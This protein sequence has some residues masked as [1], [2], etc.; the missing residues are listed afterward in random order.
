MGRFVQH[1]LLLDAVLDL[2]GEVDPESDQDGETRDGD[3]RQVH[4]DQTQDCERPDHPD[5]HAQQGQQAP[6]HPK[7]Q[8]QD[9]RHDRHRGGAEGEHAALQV[10]VDVLEEHRGARGDHVEALEV[11]VRDDVEGRLGDVRQRVEAGVAL[12]D[13]TAN[14]GLQVRER[15]LQ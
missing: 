8:Q 14:S 10:V 7:H 1:H 11:G 4:V 5:Q 3:Q 13:H 2:D 6:P 15:R 9:H 12:D